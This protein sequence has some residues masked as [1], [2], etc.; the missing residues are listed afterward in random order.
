MTSFAAVFAALGVPQVWLGRSD[1][2]IIDTAF[3]EG[4]L[5]LHL[6][7]AWRR[8]SQRSRRLHVVGLLPELCPA[9][10][11]RARLLQ[12][13]PADITPFVQALVD[14]WPLNLLGVHRLEF[15]GLCVTI[16]I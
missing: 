8:E 4:H 15:E 10:E 1:Y 7:Q 13:C 6:W 12:T 14:A 16:L 3:G 5:F 2:T 11:L 9:Q